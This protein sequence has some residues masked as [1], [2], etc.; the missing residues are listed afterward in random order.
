MTQSPPASKALVIKCLDA[1]IKAWSEN[2]SASELQVCLQID[3]D[4]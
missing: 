1:F 3:T 2:G 4:D